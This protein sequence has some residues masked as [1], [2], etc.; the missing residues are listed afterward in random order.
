V[1][2]VAA[3]VAAGV[4]AIVALA[5]GAVLDNS[6]LRDNRRYGRRV[7]SVGDVNPVDYGGGFVYKLPGD[8]EPYIEYVHGLD[9]GDTE[10]RMTLYRDSI[11]ADVFA[12]YNWAKVEEIARYIGAD[13]DELRR[14]GASRKVMDRAYAVEAIASYHGW[15]EL[16]QYPLE[17]TEKELRRRWREY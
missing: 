4:W 17:L 13:P 5:P 11:P 2:G 9:G 12:H 16:D 15:H 6:G 10:G 1:I 7:G 3:A 14:L 8:P